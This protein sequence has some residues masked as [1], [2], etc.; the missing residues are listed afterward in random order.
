VPNHPDTSPLRFFLQHGG[1]FRLFDAEGEQRADEDAHVSLIPIQPV[2]FLAHY[3][4]RSN[5]ETRFSMIRAKFSRSRSS[6][7]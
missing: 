7:D 3:R 1:D 5:V 4:K 2:S 6:R